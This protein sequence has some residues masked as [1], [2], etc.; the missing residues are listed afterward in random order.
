[1]DE[2]SIENTQAVYQAGDTVQ[3]YFNR[4]L[5]LVDCLKEKDESYTE[6]QLLIG[7]LVKAQASDFNNCLL[8]TAFFKKAEA[9]KE[10]NYEI[11]PFRMSHE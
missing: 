4:A 2:P 6:Y 8:S 10:I 1:M 7:E 11:A 3:V 9:I 5:E